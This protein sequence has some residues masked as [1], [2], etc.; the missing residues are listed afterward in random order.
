MANKKI[1]I[2]INTTANTSGA[3]KATKSIQ[4][5]EAAIDKADATAKAKAE[6]DA[7]RAARAEAAAER[8]A[9]VAQRR[10]ERE[11]KQAEAASQRKEAALKREQAAVERLQAAEEKKASK[12][13]ENAARE[14]SVSSTK[15]ARGAAIKVQQAGYQVAD[16]A[17]QV[18]GGTS[19]L[20]ALGQQLPQFLGAFGPQGAV[21]GAL[22]AV[23]LVAYK[24]F[25]GIGDS[26][27][28][29][30]ERADF[31]AKAIDE[32]ASMAAKA[33][34]EDY[35]MGY[36]A[37]SNSQAIA[38]ALRQKF[39]YIA[40][41]EGEFSLAALQNSKSLNAAQIKLQE[42]M[43]K[44]YDPK[45]IIDFYAAENEAI[46]TQEYNNNVAAEKAKQVAAE[47]AK[48]A[49]DQT[50]AQ[51]TQAFAEQQKILSE[52]EKEL[53]NLKNQKTAL[54]G[55]V[56]L[57][58]GIIQTL[59]MTSQEFDVQQSKN[60]A[61]TAAETQLKGADF[62]ARIPILEAAIKELQSQVSDTGS[63]T[64]DLNSALVESQNAKTN[65][66]STSQQVSMQLTTLA[67]SFN[68]DN[69][70]ASITKIE[71]EGKAKAETI[72]KLIDGV[73]PETTGEKQAMEQLK[74][75]VAD[76]EIKVGE[77]TQTAASL[78]TLSGKINEANSGQTQIIT[79]LITD[80]SKMKLDYDALNR[81]LDTLQAIKTTPF[82]FK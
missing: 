72:T 39:V 40:K 41:A 44:T 5:T 42:M 58:K 62:T 32:G 6:R 33:L 20:V 23:G 10:A 28:K 17:T 46:R 82:Q 79:R 56:D 51:K 48:Q 25:S 7:A 53:E 34:S 81:K 14:D 70:I 65:F 67:N 26:V 18:S 74:T 47:K 60:R 36:T 22:I 21:A 11:A 59:G 76:H 4:Q 30:K 13:A 3:D 43:G 45:Q 19:A 77:A 24:V 69:V 54:E 8:A 31:L 80:F 29:A 12:A 57:R 9:G 61:A 66:E 75:A 15:E 2:N 49:A 55:I 63:L 38:E 71:E 78:A 64:Q 27:E 68:Q 37:L 73:K 52:S 50:L 35:D 16:F 1:D